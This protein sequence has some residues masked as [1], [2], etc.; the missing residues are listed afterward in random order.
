LLILNTRHRFSRLPSRKSES[1]CSRGSRRWLQWPNLP[2]S[3]RAHGPTSQLFSR[4]LAGWR[5]HHCPLHRD[6]GLQGHS[7]SP[8]IGLQARPGAHLAL[9]HFCDSSRDH[10][11]Y[12]RGNPSP[13]FGRSSAVSTKWLCGHNVE[14]AFVESLA[15]VVPSV[16]KAQ[17]VAGQSSDTRTQNVSGSGNVN[18]EQRNA[19][20][21]AL[22]LGSQ[23]A[24]TPKHVLARVP[25]QPS[26]SEWKVLIGLAVGF[27]IVLLGTLAMEGYMVLSQSHAIGKPRI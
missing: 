11:L 26:A 9:R 5:A 17:A 18:T 23:T 22:R 10:A 25:N 8:P 19:R 4:I 16:P 27:A 6:L 14:E 3:L 1:A 7:C 24:T 13:G 15:G 12:D 2:R 20:Q 21:H